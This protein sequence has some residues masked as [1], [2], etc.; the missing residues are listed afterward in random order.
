MSNVEFMDFWV[1]H[2]YWLWWN[3]KKKIQNYLKGNKSNH[4]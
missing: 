4:K 3:K 1:A 2:C